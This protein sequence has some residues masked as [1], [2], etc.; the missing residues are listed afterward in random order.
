MPPSLR[1][2]HL[3]GCPLGGSLERPDNLPGEVRALTKLE[4]LQL[5]DGSHVGHFFGTPR[6]LLLATPAPRTITR[7]ITRTGRTTGEEDEEEAMEE[8]L[9]MVEEPSRLT[10]APPSRQ[11]LGN[12]QL[13]QVMEQVE[14]LRAQPGRQLQPPPRS[15]GPPL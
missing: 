7:T 5:P 6:E 15:S 13:T 2:L 1:V 10:V 14:Q 12:R 4:D 11:R 9:S 3:E 8:L